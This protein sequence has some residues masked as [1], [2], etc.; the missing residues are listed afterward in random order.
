M[1]AFIM[2]R[3]GIGFDP[4]ARGGVD[5]NQGIAVSSEKEAISWRKES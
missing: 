4:G 1:D 2:N 3:T 5:Q